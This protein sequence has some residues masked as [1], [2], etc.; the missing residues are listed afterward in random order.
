MG[1]RR[2]SAAVVTRSKQRSPPTAFESEPWPVELRVRM[3]VHTGEAEERDG[4]YFGP[5]LN[6]AARLMGLASGGQVLV[7]LA[8]AEVVRDRLPDGIGLVELGERSLRSLSRPERVFELCR[9]DP[10]QTDHRPAFPV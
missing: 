4:D 5:A 6:R 2:C 3:A 10:A 8:A 9:P 1:W 7:S